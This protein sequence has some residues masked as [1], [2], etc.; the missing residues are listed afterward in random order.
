MSYVGEAT[1]PLWIAVGLGLS[2]LLG[3]LSYRFVENTTRV[4]LSSLQKSKESL[5][6][7]TPASVTVVAACFIFLFN[8]FNLNVRP[9]AST[10]AAKYVDQYS[11]DNYITAY[12]KEQYKLQCNFFDGD[13][14]VAKASDIPASCTQKKHADGIFL[15]GDSHAQALSFGIRSHLKESVDFYQV[16]S[17]GC[18]PHI[19]GDNA[20]SGE[21]K[22]ACDRSNKAAIDAIARLKPSVVIMAQAG[23]HDK[24]DYDKI[25]EH[26][27][28]LGIKHIV[29]VGPVPQWQPSLPRAIALRH[30]DKNEQ[31]F[32]DS[33]FDKKL[34]DIDN[35]MKARYE[36][37]NQ[38]TYISLL[39]A[40][41]K[42]NE[43]LA[44]IDDNN[45]PLVWDYGHL[46]L[47]GSEYIA[48]E[49]L[50]V[51][52]VFLHYFNTELAH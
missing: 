13:A 38:V 2:V 45:T 31:S 43:C 35:R 1:N 23:N 39:D 18:Q 6:I 11:R 51:N 3:E 50:S 36:N 46:S 4:K 44:K 22:I 19:G 29:L 30:F 5:F 37:N 48:R 52:K 47:A 25:I 28:K 12:V 34:F 7:L 16:A 9:G 14:Y 24:N 10:L 40:L 49:V 20:T 17:S 32:S 42:G 26:L 21:F 27:S 15:W 33:S 41:C 8:G